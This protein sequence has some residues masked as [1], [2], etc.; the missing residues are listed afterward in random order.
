VSTASKKGL[1]GNEDVE[2]GL[3][4]FWDCHSSIVPKVTRFGDWIFL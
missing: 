1:L 4:G 2:V 3:L